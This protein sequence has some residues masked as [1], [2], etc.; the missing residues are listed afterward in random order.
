MLLFNEDSDAESECSILSEESLSDVSMYGHRLSVFKKMFYEAYG[1]DPE[2]DLDVGWINEAVRSQRFANIRFI[3][4]NYR[5]SFLRSADDDYSEYLLLNTLATLPRVIKPGPN[6]NENGVVDAMSLT[7]YTYHHSWDMPFFGL[8]LIRLPV[9]IVCIIVSAW[10]EVARTLSPNGLGFALHKACLYGYE[11]EVLS[12]IYE[13]NRP[14]IST[15]NENHG[16]WPLHI[17]I[18]RGPPIDKKEM[19]AFTFLLR[20][21]PHSAVAT[22]ARGWTPLQY[23]EVGKRWVDIQSNK[24]VRR[25][26]RLL[27]FYI[28]LLELVQ[29]EVAERCIFDCIVSYF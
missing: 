8:T 2:P 18:R 13:A 3:Y 22:D 5:V 9:H 6:T 25:L 17:L 20:M 7:Y 29:L 12:V 1:T 16:R 11:K 14:A 28:R 10:P 23:T 15:G 26:Q 4:N 21:A 27:R 19:S 24:A